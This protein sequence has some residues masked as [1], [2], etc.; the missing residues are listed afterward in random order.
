MPQTLQGATVQAMKSHDWLMTYFDSLINFNHSHWPTI[1]GFLVPNIYQIWA[2]GPTINE[3]LIPRT[4]NRTL[5]G[6]IQVFFS[7]I[8]LWDTWTWMTN[9]SRIDGNCW[10]GM[11]NERIHKQLCCDCRNVLLSILQALLHLIFDICRSIVICMCI[12]DTLQWKQ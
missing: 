6:K 7:G 10:Q 12:H 2:T 5:F 11:I 9:F 4:V 3:Q 8:W 1:C